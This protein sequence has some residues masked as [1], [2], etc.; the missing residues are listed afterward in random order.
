MYH[1]NRMLDYRRATDLSGQRFGIWAV[2]KRDGSLNLSGAAAFLCRCGCGIEKR[3]SGTSLRLGLSTSCGCAK[4]EKLREVN[5]THGKSNHP[6]Y[7]V[8]ANMKARCSHKRNSGFRHYGGRGIRVCERWHNFQPFYDDNI[9]DWQPGLTLDRIDNDGDYSPNNCRWATHAAQNRNKRNTVKMTLGNRTRLLID[10]AKINGI[11]V[12]ALR[13][14]RRRGWSDK[15]A[16][17]TP[18]RQ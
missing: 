16:L 4:P 15:R 18:T 2:L 17:T 8:W 3:V 7:R 6:L 1:K 13:R 12:E 5:T 10:W 14:R 11:S 9:G